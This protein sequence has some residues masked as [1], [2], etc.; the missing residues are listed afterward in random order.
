MPSSKPM[1]AY[2]AMLQP[3]FGA[4]RMSR[5]TDQDYLFRARATGKAV[6]FKREHAWSA[7]QTGKAVCHRRFSMS[8]PSPKD[9]VDPRLLDGEGFHNAAVL[10]PTRQICA[11][12]VF[13]AVAIPQKLRLEPSREVAGRQAQ[14]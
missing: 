3:T 12:R 1:A 2:L 10:G 9:G 11:Q 8:S 7:N 5:F 14:R 13:L 4:Y 6:V